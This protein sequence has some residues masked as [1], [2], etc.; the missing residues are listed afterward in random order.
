MQYNTI[1]IHHCL[2]VPLGWGVMNQRQVWTAEMSALAVV[3]SHT[4]QYRV[5][6]HLSCATA[7][8]MPL[9][10]LPTSEAH[11]EHTQRDDM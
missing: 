1:T 2:P 6:T 10:F 3:Y 7:T 5:L 4:L 9:I 8:S 11:I